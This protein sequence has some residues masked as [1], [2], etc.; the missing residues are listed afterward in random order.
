MSVTGDYEQT[1]VDALSPSKK[2]DSKQS[3]GNLLRDNDSSV[4]KSSYCA[5]KRRLPRGVYLN[6]KIPKVY[7]IKEH[8]YFQSQNCVFKIEKVI[9][10]P[11]SNNK[12]Y[13]NYTRPV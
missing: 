12:P 8:K 13:Y 9:K 3:D 1:F 2:D 5:R 10:K 4:I 11:C 6:K 7:E